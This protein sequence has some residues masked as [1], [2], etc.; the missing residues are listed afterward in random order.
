MMRVVRA[1]GVDLC[2]ETFGAQTDPA[3]L[4]V[5][6]TGN[7]MLL[8]ADDFCRRLAASRRFVIRYD[9]R[10][11]GRSVSYPPGEPRYGLRDLVD[12]A[13]G[14]LDAL[15]VDRAHVVGMSLGG[16]IGQLLAL[17]H[18]GRVAALTLASSTPGI[19]GHESPDLPGASEDLFA[20][21]LPA[22]D[23][24][25]RSAAIDYLVEA[26][27]PFAARSRP[28]DEAAMRETMGRVVDHTDDLKAS[29]T[30]PF[31]IDP[32]AP[33]RARLGAISAPTLVVHGIEDLLFPYAHAV[34]LANEI[35]GADLLPLEQTGHEYFPPGTWDRVIPAILHVGVGAPQLSGPR[36]GARGR[37]QSARTDSRRRRRR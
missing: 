5:H 1:N 20:Y 33:W 29:V 6:G 30:N 14:L 27:R 34:A 11:A 24:A 28:F 32:G 19:P 4:L 31:M 21:E 25:D 18:R 36:G 3:I 15:D 7:C 26:E 23:W 22:P 13:A 8:W 37:R 2:A 12:D 35:P 9:L 10:D 16:A 17:D